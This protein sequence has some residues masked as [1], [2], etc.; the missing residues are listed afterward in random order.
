MKKIAL[1]LIILIIFAL[2]WAALHDILKGEPDTYLEYAVLFVSLV[3]FG[4]FIFKKFK[5]SKTV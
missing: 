2:D 5:K 1:T 4:V 3:I